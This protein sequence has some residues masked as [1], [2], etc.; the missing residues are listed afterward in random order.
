MFC[1]QHK[2]IQPFVISALYH[3]QLSEAKNLNARELC[4]IITSLMGPSG[5]SWNKPQVNIF[6]KALECQKLPKLNCFLYV[7]VKKN[8]MPSFFFKVVF[9]LI[10]LRA[11]TYSP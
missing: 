6:S 5:G 7:C 11:T 1:I 10:N 3:I 2:N 4:D 9:S 8:Y